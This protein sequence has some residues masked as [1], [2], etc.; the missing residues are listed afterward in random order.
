MAKLNFKN[1]DRWFSLYIRLRD[2]DDNGNIRCCSC[3]KVV[4][5]RDADAGHFVSRRHKSTRYHERNVHGQCRA[6]NRFDEGNPAGY[7]RFLTVRY[8]HDILEFLDWKS[9]QTVKWTQFEIDNMK[10]NYKQKAEELAEKKGL[11]I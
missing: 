9:K 1:L 4:F 7:A 3:Q 5:W 8:S 11:I 2:A 10:D 6:C